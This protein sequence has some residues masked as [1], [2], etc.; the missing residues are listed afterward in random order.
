MPG[1]PLSHVMPRSALVGEASTLTDEETPMPRLHDLLWV[2]SRKRMRPDPE[3]S[4]TGLHIPGA[5]AGLASLR[6]RF[7]IWTMGLCSGKMPA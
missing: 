2:R 1:S 5:R 6:G 7:F 3:L 4:V